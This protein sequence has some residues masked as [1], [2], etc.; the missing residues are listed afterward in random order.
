MPMTLLHP[1]SD[2]ALNLALSLI[3]ASVAPVLLLDG[4]L[5][6]VAASE[7]FREA[8]DVGPE[9]IPGARLADLGSGQWNSPQ[10]WSLLKVTAYGQASIRAYEMDLATSEGVKRLVLNAQRLDNGIGQGIRLLLSIQ[11]VTEARADARQKDDLIRD[12]AILVQEMQHRVANSLQ[13]IASVL[14]QG[15]RKVGSDESGDHL[16]DAHQRIM[17]VA[18]VQRQLAGSEMGDVE[19]RGYFTDLCR[20][21]GDSMI[22]DRNRVSLKVSVDDSIAS[23]G[24]SVS[25]GLIVTELVINALKHA[26]PKDREGLIVVD[27]RAHG[28]G[29]TLMVCDD[30]VGMPKDLEAAKP[31]LG[32]GIIQALSKQ[33]GATVEQSD[34]KPGLR[35]S[36]VC[37]PIST[38]KS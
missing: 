15:A 30:G 28:E 5:A 18:A 34:G 20:S 32:T 4:D 23:S 7:S 3:A 11:D 31:G 33:L 8:F 27:Y 29:W 16:R 12:K 25:L 38:D 26:F 6:V 10:L 37:P 2:I 21:I 14:L 9:D 24:K 19:L 22:R 17:S 35:V 13:I 1:P 36:I